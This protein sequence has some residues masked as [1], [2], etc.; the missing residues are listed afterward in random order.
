[1]KVPVPTRGRQGGHGLLAAH[2][3]KP[4]DKLIDGCAILFSNSEMAGNGW[5]NL[6]FQ[7]RLNA[8]VVDSLFN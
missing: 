6:Y 8:A 3:R 1:M 7:G 4:R 2:A 5:D